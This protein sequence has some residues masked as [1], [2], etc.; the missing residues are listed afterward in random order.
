M[1]M[2]TT[3][4]SELLFAL[5]SPQ[6]DPDDGNSLWVQTPGDLLAVVHKEEHLVHKNVEDADNWTKVGMRW[7]MVFETESTIL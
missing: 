5:S 6:R 4:M 2:S 7:L 3:F 1:V